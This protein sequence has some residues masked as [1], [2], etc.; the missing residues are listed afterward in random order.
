M[1]DLNINLEDVEEIGG[2]DQLPAGNFRAVIDDSEVKQ[3]KK[4]DNMLVLTIE[5]VGGEHSGRRLWDYFLL[6]NKIAL[7]RLKGLCKTLKLPQQLTSAEVFLQK[8]V[9]IKVKQTPAKDGYE[10]GNSITSY[11]EAPTNG[12]VAPSAGQA[13]TT[14]E[15]C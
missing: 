4:G 5:L 12:A 10:A 6:N 1:N 15:W 8:E 3:S 13:A 14:P 11:K 9:I 2:F 7:G